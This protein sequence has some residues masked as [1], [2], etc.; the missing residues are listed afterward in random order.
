MATGAYLE[1]LVEAAQAARSAGHGRKEAIYAAAAAE[2]GVSVSTIKSKIGEINGRQ[3]KRRADAGEY[4]LSR[5]DA[6]LIAAYWRETTRGT[7]KRLLTLENAVDQLRANGRIQAGRVDEETGEFSPLSISAIARA[8]RG[9]GIHPDQLTAPKPV[10]RLISE[11]PNQ[12]WQLDPSLCVLYYLRPSADAVDG[13]KVM[14]ADQFYKNKPAN[15][16]KVENER[17]WRYVI[18][19]HASGCLFVRYVLGAESAVNLVD[20]FLAAI[21]QRNGEPFHGVPYRLMMDPGS[22]NTSATARN[23]FHALQVE[24]LINRP[25]NPRAKGQVENANNLVERY[26]EAG[27]RMI[28]VPD[29]DRLNALAGKWGC[30]FNGSSVHSRHGMTRFGAWQLI[31]SDQ[32]RL[33]PS[34]DLCREAAR[35]KSETRKV[36]P[37]L[38]ISFG[39]KSYHVDQVPGILV[40]E[41]VEVCRNLYRE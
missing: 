32:L 17:V 22:A 9:Y 27:L 10:T 40:G 33:A 4:T 12:V 24:L 23:L 25:G 6:D 5:E 31:R 7:G 41:K 30:W 38:K 20:A 8:M 2:L 1:R 19:D 28:P 16:A 29:L 13:L 11:F 35:T 37:D 21:Q 26:F 36:T 18:T 14:P 39:G 15:L 34:L 3:R